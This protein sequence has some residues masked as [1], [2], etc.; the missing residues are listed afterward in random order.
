MITAP[1]RAALLAA[2]VAVVLLVAAGLGAAFIGPAWLHLY[3]PAL[4]LPVLMQGLATGINWRTAAPMT[5][6]EL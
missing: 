6:E 5:K 3:M 1:D 4:E 2:V